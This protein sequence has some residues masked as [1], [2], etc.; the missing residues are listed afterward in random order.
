MTKRVITQHTDGAFVQLDDQ[1]TQTTYQLKN[2]VRVSGVG[3]AAVGDYV[4]YYGAETGGVVK[5]KVTALHWS[6]SLIS[7]RLHVCG[8]DTDIGN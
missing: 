5:G 8:S 2:G 6:G 4:M 1:T 7:L 3:R